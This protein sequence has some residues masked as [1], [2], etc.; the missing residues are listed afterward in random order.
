MMVISTN[1]VHILQAFKCGAYIDIYP[2]PH[3]AL[4]I[5]TLQVHCSG[6]KMKKNIKRI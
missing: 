6:F 5:H 2:Y 1:Q 4:Y 3:H